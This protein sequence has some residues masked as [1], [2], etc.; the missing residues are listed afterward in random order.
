M[1]GNVSVMPTL[2]TKVVQTSVG[3]GGVKV[4]CV[5]VGDGGNVI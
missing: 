1:S 4:K 3:L 2:S 5:P